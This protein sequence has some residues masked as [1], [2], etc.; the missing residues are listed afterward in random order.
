MLKV[1]VVQLTQMIPQ[2]MKQ[3]LLMDSI[4]DIDHCE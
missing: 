4:Q 3:D 1:T 2:E